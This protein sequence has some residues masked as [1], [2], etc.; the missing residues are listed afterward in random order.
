ML[1][2]GRGL[3][4]HILVILTTTIILIIVM[5]LCLWYLL[6]TECQ[7]M[8]LWICLH[9]VI[10][11][12]LNCTCR[13]FQTILCHR[14]VCQHNW[15]GSMWEWITTRNYRIRLNSKTWRQGRKRRRVIRNDVK[16][17]DHLV[18][19]R[20]SIFDDNSLVFFLRNISDD[21]LMSLVCRLLVSVFVFVFVL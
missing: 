6:P 20:H 16:V 4:N 12:F 21:L 9:M 13:G 18:Y 14:W 5:Y 10:I 11:I 15:K 17:F 2:V 3:L 1:E 19:F 8:D 7:D